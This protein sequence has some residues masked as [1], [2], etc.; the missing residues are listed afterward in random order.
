MKED[1]G[2]FGEPGMRTHRGEGR[3]GVVNLVLVRAQQASH[4]RNPCEE[5][6][7]TVKPSRIY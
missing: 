6:F 7:P 2:G 4:R 1:T 5:I 3:L